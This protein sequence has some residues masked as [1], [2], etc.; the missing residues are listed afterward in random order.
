[1]NYQV[2]YRTKVLWLPALG[3]LTLSSSLLA[4]FQFSG[5][6]P[7]SYWLSGTS[8]LF[9]TFYLPWLIVLPVIGAAA[10]FW[11]QR[12]GGRAIHRLLAALAPPIGMLGFFLVSPFLTLLIYMLL[13]LFTH[14]AVP[15]PFGLGDLAYIIP[16]VLVMLVSWVLLPAVGLLLGAVPFLRKPQ[17]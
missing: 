5:L 8:Y 11:S 16:G 10:A 13:T 1:M 3:A 4:I 6:V 7:R 14:R 2:T 15:R 12:A 17:P 9:F